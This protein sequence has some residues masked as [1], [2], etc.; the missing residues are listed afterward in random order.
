MTTNNL[1]AQNTQPPVQVGLTD[2]QS[3]DFAQRVAKCFSMS[4]LVP[5]DYQNNLP[6]CVIAL[7]MA[8]RMGADPMMIMQ[9]LVA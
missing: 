1:P 6:N 2:A 8:H 9:N 7:N 5:K 3:F 4:S